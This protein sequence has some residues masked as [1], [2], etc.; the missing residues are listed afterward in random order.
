MEFKFRAWNKRTRSMEYF[1]D[2]YWF[3][4]NGVHSSEDNEWVVM[5][6]IGMKDRDGKDIYERDL[7]N[8]V[9][10]IEHWH[11]GFTEPT[12]V[13]YEEG[14]FKPLGCGCEFGI[15]LDE[16]VVVGNTCEDK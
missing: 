2:L 11:G 16:A 13:C 12:E 3:E 9:E 8:Y 6:C 10:G 15:D 5:I 7:I 1:D 14:V 4:E